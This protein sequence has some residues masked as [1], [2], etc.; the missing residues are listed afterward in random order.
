MGRRGPKPTP[1]AVLA[2]RGSWRVTARGKEPQPKKGRPPAPP[3]LSVPARKVWNAVVKELEEMKILGTC[4]GNALARYAQAVANY[5]QC[6]K[7]I[8]KKGMT[9]ERIAT[10]GERM[11]RERPEVK[12]MAAYS[13]EC[14]KL[15]NLFGLNPSARA[16]LA[17]A[18]E[19]N[20][21]EN[22]GKRKTK[23]RFFAKAAGA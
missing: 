18:K 20:P 12:L 8:T 23:A 13:E 2:A 11:I 9:Y 3:G 7:V 17:P 5:W 15:E 16:N 10:N 6:S 1:K 4:D 21:A 14:R 19:S 22:R